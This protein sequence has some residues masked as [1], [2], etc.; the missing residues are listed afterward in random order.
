MICAGSFLLIKKAPQQALLK[1]N[2]NK[3]YSKFLS[4]TLQ[5]KLAKKSSIYFPF[6][7]G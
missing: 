2:L 5:F 4:I 7:E 3:I 6:P 1:N